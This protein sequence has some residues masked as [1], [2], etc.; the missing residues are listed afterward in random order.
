MVIINLGFSWEYFARAFRHLLARAQW[1]PHRLETSAE[2][3]VD[4]VRDPTIR[5]ENISAHQHRAFDAQS[6]LS[7]TQ[8]SEQ[9]LRDSSLKPS[10]DRRSDELTAQ[11]CHP[12]LPDG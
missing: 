7:L 10:I 11:L 9:L 2:W 6:S 1:P 12:S 4:T 3:L 5:A 8:A